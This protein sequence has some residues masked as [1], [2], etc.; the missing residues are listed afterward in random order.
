MKAF[1][2]IGAVLA[3]VLIVLVFLVSV[4]LIIA[5]I[6]ADKENGGQPNVFGYVINSVQSDSMAP[7]F[8]KALWS[9]VSW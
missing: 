3:D 7:T 4:V 8:S 5:N 1:K 2:K 9:S 6:T